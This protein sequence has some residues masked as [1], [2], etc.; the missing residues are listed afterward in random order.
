MFVSL[1]ECCLSCLRCRVLTI[2]P[3]CSSGASH[4]ILLVFSSFTLFIYLFLVAGR[5]WTER[6]CLQSGYFTSIQGINGECLVLRFVRNW[7]HPGRQLNH[8]Q[9][10]E[11]LLLI[12]SV[13]L[14]AWAYV[15][16]RIVCSGWV[17][18][19]R[20]SGCKFQSVNSYDVAWRNRKIMKFAHM[21][22]FKLNL[23]IKLSAECDPKIDIVNVS[24]CHVHVK[25][26]MQMQD[27]FEK[28][29][30]KRGASA[31]SRVQGKGTYDA[32]C[33]RQSSQSCKCNTKDDSD[34]QCHHRH[35]RTANP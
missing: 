26:P 17:P 21:K 4:L 9:R 33:T 29:G 34:R 13:I 32:S 10:K 31:H 7:I 23:Y 2:S 19:L 6:K 15:Y 35:G 28:R 18:R 12:Y 30:K 8:P 11:K 20:L 24:H 22:L 16:Y 27:P 25:S 3:P 1:P 5:T 14:L